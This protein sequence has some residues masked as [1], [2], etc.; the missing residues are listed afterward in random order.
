VEDEIYAGTYQ[1]ELNDQRRLRIGEKVIEV[2]PKQPRDDELHVYVSLPSKVGGQVTAHACR[3]PCMI[4]CRVE[5]RY[6]NLAV[7]SN[8]VI[9]T[10]CLRT[11]CLPNVMKP[12]IHSHFNLQHGGDALMTRVSLKR[13]S[14]FGL[15]LVQDI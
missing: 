11:G 13:V 9:P 7:E 2:W 15:C 10:V 12:V 3:Y 4:T 5:W 1:L 14:G 8:Q 6:S